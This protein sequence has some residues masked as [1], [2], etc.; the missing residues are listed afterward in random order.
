MPSSPI[1]D[2]PPSRLEIA[3]TV[4]VFPGAGQ[5]VQGRWI[6]AGLFLCSGFIL[7]GALVYVAI[8]PVFRNLGI[9]L[10]MWGYTGDEPLVAPSI[11]AILTMAG[12]LI[13]LH[14]ASI[15]DVVCA[16]RKRYLRWQQWQ[17]K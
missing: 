17:Q 8:V 9:A 5:L 3:L 1:P 11:P 2:D 10:A 16:Y 15:V 14:V 7:V 13:A 4:V 6:S 12:A